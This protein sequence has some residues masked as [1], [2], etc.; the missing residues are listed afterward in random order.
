MVTDR[1]CNN[2]L[3]TTEFGVQCKKI[4]ITYGVTGMKNL[5]K[6]KKIKC[7]KVRALFPENKV[8]FARAEQLCS[9]RTQNCTVGS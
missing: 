8:R 5:Q 6:R 2:K 4:S 7:V 1:S 3:V 9:V